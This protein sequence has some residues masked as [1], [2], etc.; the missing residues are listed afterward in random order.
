ML[1]LTAQTTVITWPQVVI[2]AV[3]ALGFLLSLYNFWIARWEERPKLVIA[4]GFGFAASPRAEPFY[5]L[6]VLVRDDFQ[7]CSP[8]L[9]RDRTKATASISIV[10]WRFDFMVKDRLGFPPACLS[11]TICGD[12]F[13]RISHY[14]RKTGSDDGISVCFAIG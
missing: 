2:A 12:E 8:S 14:R 11:D 4:S 10:E 5:S 6:T 1:V 13:L 7:R 3:A 9:A